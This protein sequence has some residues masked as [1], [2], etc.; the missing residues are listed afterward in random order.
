M[1]EAS[2][3]ASL[4]RQIDERVAQNGGGRA[5]EVRVEVGPLAGV[6]PLLFDQAFRRLR[7]GTSSADAELVV[8]AVGLACRCRDCAAEYVTAELSFTCLSCGGR[9]VDVTS[10]DAVVLHSFTLAQPAETAMT[11]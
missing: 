3:V 6:E 1:H 8:E 11:R 4:L 9:R 7:A 2:L 5:V 10:G